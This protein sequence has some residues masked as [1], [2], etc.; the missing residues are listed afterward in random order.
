MKNDNLRAAAILALTMLVFAIED[1]LIK[2]L[3]AALPVSEVLGILAVVGLLVFGGLLFAQSERFWTKDLL[4]P[5]VLLRNATE[6][7][8][9]VAIVFAFAATE[10]STTV[11][12]LQATPLFL[13]LGATL[14]LK[15]PVG[16]RRTTAIIAGFVGVIMVVRPG[17]AGFQPASLWAV[18]AAA[19]FAQRDLVTRRV[20]PGMS[21]PQLS[22]AAFAALLIAS[23]VIAFLFGETPVMPG[24]R[25]AALA[26]ACGVVT[27]TGYVLLVAATRIGEASILAPVRYTRL[28]FALV[29]AVVVFGERL[30]ALTLAGAVT[31]VA[32]GC[33]T[34]WREAFLARRRTPDASPV[35]S[36]PTRSTLEASVPKVA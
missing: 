5:P 27:V 26:L 10:L 24:P 9:S 7:V 2:V 17:L 20:P 13:T 12:L 8:A 31:I 36:I 33:Y 6:T 16:W 34:V 21:S 35:L 29:L 23:V 3:A 25:I 4:T 18:F 19:G 11:A 14:W 15:E 32:S 30:D 28:V 1:A 22:A